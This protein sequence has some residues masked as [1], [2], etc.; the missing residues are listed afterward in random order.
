ML[1]LLYLSTCNVPASLYYVKSCNLSRDKLTNYRAIIFKFSH[2]L[3]RDKFELSRDNLSKKK[4]A[5]FLTGHRGFHF[6]HRRLYRSIIAKRR[7][8]QGA[9]GR[10]YP[11]SRDPSIFYLGRSKGLCS[12]GRKRH[13]WHIVQTSDETA[14]TFW[15]LV[16]G[17]HRG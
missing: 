5:M 7:A 6:P 10:G 9:V 12:E 8:A 14:S 17:S 1:S 3:A 4:N 16:E 15:R 11:A 13:E 2:L